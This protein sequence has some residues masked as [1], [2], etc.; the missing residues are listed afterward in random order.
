MSQCRFLI[1]ECVPHSLARGLTRRLPAAEVFSVGDPPAPGKGIPDE[2]LLIYCE[3]NQ[4]LL[5]TADRSS[6]PGWIE[7]H[8]QAGRHTWGVL[9]VGPD[10]S[11]SLILDNLEILFEAS[12]AEEWIDMLFYLPF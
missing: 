7:K 10:A 11:T 9:F 2:D 1:D 6:M 4:L 3:L 8:L 12:V 5:I